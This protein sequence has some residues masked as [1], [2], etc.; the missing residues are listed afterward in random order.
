MRN[1]KTI[2]AAVA[3][4]LACAALGAQAQ[5]FP[6]RPIHF[7][8]PY[9][10]G[11]GT[12][13]VARMMA[14]PMGE[15]LGQSV[16]IENKPGAAAILG[17]KALKDAKPDGYTIGALV[18]ANAIQTW[19]TKDLGFDIRKDFAPI[20]LLYTGPLVMSVP[21]D[22]PAKNLAEFVA[23]AKANPTK[24]FYG[25]VGPG[26]TSHLASEMLKL[27]AGINLT[28]VP[29]KGSPEMY[30]GMFSGGV[31]LAFDNYVTPKPQ[32]EAGKLKVL[33]ITSLQRV[34]WLPNI[35]TFAETF[36]N[37]EASFWVGLAAPQGTP[38][39]ALDRVTAEARAALQRPDIRDRMTQ[40]GL[41]QGGGTP[42][43]FAR[44]MANE[45]EKWGKVTQAA[46]MKPE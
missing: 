9:T 20:T 22:F 37:F 17:V 41:L 44:Y 42:A 2:K 13:I 39:D 16:I 28:H 33:G 1:M 11:T 8:V 3:G 30:T 43:E 40:L 21:A 26:S 36:P 23:Y 29:Y 32:V 38:K 18:S 19:I 4:V 25:S 45:V 24:L 6:N 15:K 27:A 5:A 14:G 12:D 34:S 31:Q 46:G 10:S 35:P 7:L